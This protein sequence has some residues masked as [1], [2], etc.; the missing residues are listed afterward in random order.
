MANPVVGTAVCSCSFG[1][2][3]MPLQVVSQQTV[4]ICGMMAATIMDNVCTTFGLEHYD[5]V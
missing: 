4:H 3:P 5:Q 2:A 1:A